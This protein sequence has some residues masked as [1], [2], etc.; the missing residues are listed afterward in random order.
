MRDDREKFINDLTRWLDDLALHVKGDT[1]EAEIL[2][3][4]LRRTK[5]RIEEAREGFLKNEGRS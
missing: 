5:S 1:W 2:T 4:A 3:E